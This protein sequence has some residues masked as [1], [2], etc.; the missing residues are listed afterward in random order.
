MTTPKPMTSTSPWLDF[1]GPPAQHHVWNNNGLYG[2]T[3]Q[4]R[5]LAMNGS[6]PC[7]MVMSGDPHQGQA[8]HHYYHH[9]HM[10]HPSIDIPGFEGDYIH[11]PI[12]HD[13]MPL[14]EVHGQPNSRFTGSQP[15]LFIG[16]EQ[17]QPFAQTTFQSETQPRRKSSK[18]GSTLKLS[19]L[20]RS[21]SFSIPGTWGSLPPPP[22]PVP[23]H[24]MRDEPKLQTPSLSPLAVVRN[25]RAS[26]V[27]C[28]IFFL[29][30][31]QTR[32]LFIYFRSFHMT[33]IGSTNTIYDK[34]VDGVLGTQT[35][36]SRI[37]G[38]DESTELW[39]QPHLLN[40][41]QLLQFE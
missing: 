37:V 22:P 35:R 16:S 39:L 28:W 41:Y 9:Q 32:P 5:R 18:A 4:Q 17:V 12:F 23:Q 29:K 27:M 34:S 20:K 25:R 7:L 21:E 8:F 38:T 40:F 1:E 36:C 31:C 30:M 19:R 26:Q 2:Q 11:A 14:P 24:M 13:G 3:G 10:H 6:Q 15:C 33:N